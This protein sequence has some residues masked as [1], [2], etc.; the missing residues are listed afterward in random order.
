MRQCAKGPTPSKSA[1]LLFPALNPSAKL[2]WRT[3]GTDWAPAAVSDVAR[4]DLGKLTRLARAH[5]RLAYALGRTHRT[6]APDETNPP[7]EE[8]D[9]DTA[10]ARWRDVDQR[11]RSLLVVDLDNPHRVFVIGINP[12]FPPEWRN[13]AWATL[14]PD[15]LAEWSVRWR[16]W[17]A[18]TTAGGFRHYHDRLRTWET[19]R[20]LAEAQADLLATARA[21]ED[22]TNAWTRKPAFIEARRHVLALPPPPVVPA[23]GPPPRAAGDD[24][25]TPGQQ[26]RQEAVTRHRVPLDQA[27]LEFSRTVPSAFKRSLPS[28]PILE[29]EEFFDWLDPVVRAGQGLYLWI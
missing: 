8:I 25:A 26:E 3:M 20:L 4:E 11:L 14:L 1:P 24:R 9:H 23:P 29:V 7:E 16:H 17:H 10:L 28:L 22:R 27:A 21:T 19:S 6:A 5:T 13:A 2:R 12:I 18:E 15:E